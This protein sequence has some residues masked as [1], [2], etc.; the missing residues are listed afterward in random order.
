MWLSC[1]RLLG[2]YFMRENR[3]FNAR[4]GSPFCGFGY[5][6]LRASSSSSSASSSSS[7]LYSTTAPEPPYQAC[8]QD[9]LVY[10]FLL[11]I[12]SFVVSF[13]VRTQLGPPMLVRCNAALWHYAFLAI[14]VSPDAE[15]QYSFA[16]PYSFLIILSLSSLGTCYLF[17]THSW[18]IFVPMVTAVKNYTTKV[19]SEY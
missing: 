17:S 16:T 10:L 19:L 14:F 15:T 7:L 9:S 18:A 13:L 8:A 5:R 1:Q 2:R 6:R 4:T 11:F 3:P 12:L